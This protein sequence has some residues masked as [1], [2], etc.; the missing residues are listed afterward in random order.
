MKR[1]KVGLNGF[2]RIGRAFTRIALAR[3]SFDIVCINTRKTKPDIMAYLLKY[4]SIY[5]KYGKDVK[6]DMDGIVV[7]GKKIPS[8]N[9][10]QIESIPWD[11]YGVD[12]VIDATGAFEKKEELTKHLKG[13]AKKVILTQPSKDDNVNHLVLGVNDSAFDLK[14]EQIIS[15]CSCTTNS[16]APL[17]KVLDDNFKVLYGYL[18]TVHAYTS[19]QS[20]LDDANKNFTRSRAAA[21]NIVPTTTGA[22]ET[23]VKT[24]P[25]LKGRIDGMAMRVPV[26]TGSFTDI[27]AVVEKATTRE[28]IN[29]VFKK[30]SGESM[31]GVLEYVE[32][33]IVS[34]D[35]IG[36]PFSSIFDS[37]YTKAVSGHLVKVFAWYDNEW[38]YSAR[39]VD[40]V[41]KLSAYV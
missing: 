6:A 33:A 29:A 9:N 5:R 25:H 12:V 40:L 17:F 36:S 31:K 10:A 22:A 2:G 26:P 4:D 11:K 39:L 34:S 38:G 27:S 16:A 3:N 20:L 19:S 18:T 37:N 30:A 23:V 35:V 15:N 8:L 14:N 28:E 32:D 41:E 1:I 13:S 7:D 21:L 24:L